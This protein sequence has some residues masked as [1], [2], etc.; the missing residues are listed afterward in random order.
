MNR[1]ERRELIAG[2]TPA[3]RGLPSGKR[4]LAPLDPQAGGTWLALDPAGLLVAL[5]NLNL[6]IHEQA[7]LRPAL[8]T[9]S[10]SRGLFP[11]ALLDASTSLEMAAAW[12]QGQGMAM[13]RTCLPFRLVVT[14][15][16]SWLLWRSVD[17]AVPKAEP[18]RG[19]VMVTSSSLGDALVE[20]PR[21]QHFAA[22]CRAGFDAVAQRAF[23]LARDPAAPHLGVNMH[24]PDACTVS[25]TRAWLGPNGS[26][27]ED[28]PQ[29]RLAQ[30]AAARACGA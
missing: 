7:A 19:P 24:R 21:R 25:I 22:C 14:D 12:L 13:A 3:W 29:V 28:V 15:G 5:L 10:Q 8:S 18:L 1:D 11:L 4:V 23:H 16:H 17:A 2:V 27:M 6:P 9:R 30:S 26:G 20:P